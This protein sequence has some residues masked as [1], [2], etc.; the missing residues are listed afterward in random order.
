VNSVDNVGVV[1]VGTEVFV[2]LEKTWQ[3]S[4]GSFGGAHL[5]P[6]ISIRRGQRTDGRVLVSCI[7]QDVPNLP[8][9]VLAPV[10]VTVAMAAHTSLNPAS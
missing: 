2:V 7:I 4:I 5:G 9:E 8:V 3:K 6:D 1:G 10:K